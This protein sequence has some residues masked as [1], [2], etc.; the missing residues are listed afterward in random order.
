MADREDLTRLVERFG[1]LRELDRS[2]LHVFVVGPGT[3]E[4]I[5]VALPGTGW[6][7]IDACKVG[8][9]VPLAR[10]V[11]RYRQP[12][13]EIAM[14]LSHPHEDHASGFAEAVESLKPT[15]IHLTAK[16]PA[17]P[18]LLECVRKLLEADA[19]TSAQLRKRP[20]V[21]AL[22]A[23]EAWEIDSG[24]KLGILLEG[25]SLFTTEKVRA[26]ACAPRQGA[27]LDDILDRLAKGDR[28][29]ANEASIVIEIAFG[30]T[31]LVLGGDLTRLR[32][33]SSVP[34]GWDAVM[35]G[36]AELAEHGFLKVAHHGSVEA[37]HPALMQP[38]KAGGPDRRAWCCTPFD[39][40]S[41]PDHAEG[42]PAIL[43]ANPTLHLTHPPAAWTVPAHSG[44]I[45]LDRIRLRRV[46]D[47]TGDSFADAADDIRPR[48]PRDSLAPIWSFAFDD[49]GM[50]KSLWR[51]ESALAITAT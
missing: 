49:A 26:R 2:L 44:T 14:I 12:D 27:H 31:R 5:A 37:H 51:G 11:E 10:I 39:R 40:T 46:A 8:S 4:G 42:M 25:S 33:R 32:G 22:K 18:H 45:G 21:S 17:G 23:I 38:G 28:S 9:E 1:D 30:Q 47:P 20:V 13:E 36:H 41:L 7:V 48:A 3:G 16:T 29:R 19:S 50:L 35:A 15:T 43:A 24:R 34:T 6:L